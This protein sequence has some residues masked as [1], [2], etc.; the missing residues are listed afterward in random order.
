[1]I[2]DKKKIQKNL[3]NFLTTGAK[4]RNLTQTAFIM[5]VATK[6]GVSYWAVTSWTRV[7]K[8]GGRVPRLP[9]LHL[10]ESEFKVKIL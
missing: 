6:L 2:P 3:V 1:M 4:K 5:E 10:I 7:G 8:K 9:V